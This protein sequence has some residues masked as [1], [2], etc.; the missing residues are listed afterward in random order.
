M[1]IVV[2]MITVVATMITAILQKIIIV[3]QEVKTLCKKDNPPLY[4]VL[5]PLFITKKHCIALL[6]VFHSHHHNT[7]I[8]IKSRYVTIP[9]NFNICVHN[10]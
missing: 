7:I 2:A 4:Y 8:N 5:S 6:N 1:I 9:A 10:H 3:P